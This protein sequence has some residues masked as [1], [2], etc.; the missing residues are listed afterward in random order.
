MQLSVVERVPICPLD[1]RLPCHNPSSRKASCSRRCEKRLTKILKSIPGLL[2]PDLIQPRKVGSTEHPHL[3]THDGFHCD[4]GCNFRTASFQLIKRHFSGQ[5]MQGKCL[6]SGETRSSKDLDSLFHYVYLQ[7]WASGPGRQYWIVKRNGNQQRPIG[8]DE[9][10]N[11]LRLVC[12][13]HL[14]HKQPGLPLSP[15]GPA[16]PESSKLTFAEKGPWLE[17]TGWEDTYQ[18]INRT[19]LSKLIEM[20]R[21]KAGH[22][23]RI[24]LP[25]RQ[26]DAESGE[27]RSADDEH[28]IA[29]I[30]DLFDKAMDRCEGTV[31]KTSRGLLCWLRSSR[32]L[33]CYPKPFTFVNY[34]STTKKYRL[35]FKRCLALVIRVYRMDPIGRTKLL[36]ARLSR[37]QVRYLDSIWSHVYWDEMDGAASTQKRAGEPCATKKVYD[38][39]IEEEE[40]EDEYQD[41]DLDTVAEGAW[42]DEDTD[43]ETTD[44]EDDMNDD[45]CGAFSDEEDYEDLNEAG[46][47]IKTS[48]DSAGH[49]DFAAAEAEEDNA[50]VQAGPYE[51]LLQYV[52]GLS[53]SLCTQSLIDGQPSSTILIF[54]GGILGFSPGLNTFLPARSYTSYLSGLIYIQRLIILEYALPLRDYPALGITRRPRTRQLERLEVTRKTYMVSGA[55]SAFEEMMSLRNYGRVMAQSDPLT[56]LLRWSDDSQT[57]FYGDIL[58]VTMSDFRRL[59]RYFID[60]AESLCDD[61]MFGWKPTIDLSKLKDDMTNMSRGFSFVQHPDNQLQA[62]YLELLDKACTMRRHGLYRNGSWDRKA[63]YA[64]IKKDDSLRASFAGSLQTATGQVVRCKELFSLWCVN[65]EFGARGFYIYKGFMIFIIRHHKAKRSTNREFAVA[66]FIP[67]QIGHSL[68]KYLVFIRPLVEMLYRELFTGQKQGLDF[69]PPLLPHRN[70]C[71]K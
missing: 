41:E 56:F 18:G 70:A 49:L 12:E 14:Q 54:A 40:E 44:G 37:K 63:V 35:L 21:R 39:T 30:L 64:Y 53:I 34:D 46:G 52:F 10:Q 38:K 7:T 28:R 57:V 65:D 71:W 47:S 29:M 15:P 66:R 48:N 4:G 43:I 69:S 36:R 8:G 1:C 27:L 24:H 32:P 68:F 42:N 50:S 58:Q 45:D 31:K 61:M 17:R 22:S 2:I 13:R 16:Y 33:A 6:H 19:M 51:E 55:Q 9:V 67:V 3:R 23:A 25:Y 60:E 11:H 20:P 5:Q 59:P 62:A 26:S